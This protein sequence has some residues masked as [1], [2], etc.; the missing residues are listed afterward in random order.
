MKCFLLVGPVVAVQ[1]SVNK[2]AGS[3]IYV[4]VFVY[5]TVH[6]VYRIWIAKINP[7]QL[8]KCILIRRSRC[9]STQM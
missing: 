8:E 9:T 5:T 4:D 3:Q 6:T 2:S 1:D 7:Q